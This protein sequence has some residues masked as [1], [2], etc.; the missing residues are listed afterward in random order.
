M[1]TL[2]DKIQGNK[3]RTNKLRSKIVYQGKIHLLKNTENNRA[4]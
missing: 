4:S 1:I 2:N 3:L